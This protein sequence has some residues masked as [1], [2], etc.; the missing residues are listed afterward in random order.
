MGKIATCQS[1]AFSELDHQTLEG[2]SAVLCGTTLSRMHA[3]RAIGIATQWTRYLEGPS[4]V[5]WGRYCCQ[6]TLVIRIAAKTLAS[7]SAIALA[8][9]RPSKVDMR[10]MPASSRFRCVMHPSK[11]LTPHRLRVFSLILSFAPLLVDDL[12]RFWV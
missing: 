4:S 8:R 9:F 6:R 7:G 1:L 12:R 5:S 11:R 3:N 2:H 10:Y